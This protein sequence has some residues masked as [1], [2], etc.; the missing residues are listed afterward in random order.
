MTIR[1]GIFG[2]GNLVIWTIISDFMP[3]MYSIR[4]IFLLRGRFFTDIKL[5]LQKL[6]DEDA[7]K[8]KQTLEE[9]GRVGKGNI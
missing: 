9:I 1:A 5:L 8:V 6:Y 7:D 3:R 2:I 4:T